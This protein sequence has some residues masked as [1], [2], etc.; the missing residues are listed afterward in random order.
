MHWRVGGQN[1]VARAGGSSGARSPGIADSWD[2]SASRSASANTKL[3]P[4]TLPAIPNHALQP[5][6]HPS[7]TWLI[8]RDML[9]VYS[10]NFTKTEIS[11]FPEHKIILNHN[12]G[13]TISRNARHHIH[14]SSGQRVDVN[15]FDLEELQ[16]PLL[17]DLRE[18]HISYR[19]LR[20][21]VD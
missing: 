15:V 21:E 14:P 11:T 13:P 9:S 2:E 6:L 1:E 18:P 20:I 8:L 12:D 10:G 3:I 4:Q 5:Y 17:Y 16:L 7:H 19:Q